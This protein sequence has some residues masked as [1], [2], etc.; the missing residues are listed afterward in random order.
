MGKQR[1]CL[2]FSN[3]EDIFNYVGFATYV[4]VTCLGTENF[5]YDD[6]STKREKQLASG[7]S[8]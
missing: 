8:K 7:H 5:T 2:A 3:Q 6:N 1:K 4:N